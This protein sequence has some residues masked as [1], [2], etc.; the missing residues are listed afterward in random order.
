MVAVAQ[1]DEDMRL[2]GGQRS[3]GVGIRADVGDEHRANFSG[4]W[5]ARQRG[6][7]TPQPSAAQAALWDYLQQGA[8]GP[9][10]P[11]DTA[12]VAL[13]QQIGREHRA[14]LAAEQERD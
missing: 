8:E 10:P 12:A 13:L 14:V 4:P 2:V 11:P 3:P 6:A 1:P 7:R 5:L 9:P